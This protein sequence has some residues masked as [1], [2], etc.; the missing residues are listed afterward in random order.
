MYESTAPAIVAKAGAL[1]ELRRSERQRS[2]TARFVQS[3]CALHLPLLSLALGIGAIVQGRRNDHATKITTKTEGELPPNDN[4]DIPCE[5]ALGF[6][7]CDEVP[8][9]GLPDEEDQA[10]ARFSGMEEPRRSERERRATTRFEEGWFGEWLP[11]LSSALG[12]AVIDG[13]VR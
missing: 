13:R 12:V 8:A 5:V 3:W 7:A 9:L 11:R 1:N 4:I 10:F 6:E 2:A